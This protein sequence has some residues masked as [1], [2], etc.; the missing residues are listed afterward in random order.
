MLLKGAS[1]VEDKIQSER[2]EQDQT[3]LRSH[4]P[5]TY[6]QVQHSSAAG[7]TITA[8]ATSR[9]PIHTSPASK[10]SAI[11]LIQY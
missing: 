1:A 10:G 3:L 9:I 2:D 4:L 7:A 11:I 5:H 6:S 8:G